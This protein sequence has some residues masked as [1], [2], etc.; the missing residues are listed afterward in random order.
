M[1]AILLGFSYYATAQETF[2]ASLEGKVVDSINE[3]SLTGIKVF[4]VEVELNDSTDSRGV[5]NFSDLTSSSFTIRIEHDDYEVYEE[6]ITL[7]E[8]YNG[9]VIKLKAKQEQEEV[10]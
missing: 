5:F 8:G 9:V 1:L 3:Q 7:E 10:Q 2:T 6:K 4:L